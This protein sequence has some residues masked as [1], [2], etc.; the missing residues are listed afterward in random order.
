MS[1][2]DRKHS[3]LL[4]FAQPLNCQ[5]RTFCCRALKLEKLLRKFDM[6]IIMNCELKFA[7]G[8]NCFDLWELYE[9]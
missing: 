5:I 7:N 3:A 4:L 1:H 9:I 2:S 6:M 8:N